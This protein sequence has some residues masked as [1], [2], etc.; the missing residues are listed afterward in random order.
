MGVNQL[1]FDNLCA[2]AGFGDLKSDD[3]SGNKPLQRQAVWCVMREQ[4]ITLQEIAKQSHRAHGTVFSGVKRFEGF[5]SVNDR[6]AVQMY[7]SIIIT[8][9]FFPIFLLPYPK[10][11][12]LF[13]LG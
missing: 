6:E 13:S 1:L 3:R 11:K 5:L 10:G 2:R 4:G 12:L 7:Q 9:P 8:G